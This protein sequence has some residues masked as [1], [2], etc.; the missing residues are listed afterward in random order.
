MHPQKE[1]QSFLKFRDEKKVSTKSFL[2]YWWSVFCHKIVGHPDKNRQKDLCSFQVSNSLQTHCRKW[3][4]QVCTSD[5]ESVHDS[6]HSIDHVENNLTASVASNTNIR[7]HKATG[8]SSSSSNL[9]ASKMATSPQ[10]ASPQGI[11]TARAEQILQVVELVR[12]RF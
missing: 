1:P 2:I 9:S 4:S 11:D 6:E 7:E 10:S 5:S 12:L 3:L 8:S